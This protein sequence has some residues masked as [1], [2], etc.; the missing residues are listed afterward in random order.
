M[1]DEEDRRDWTRDVLSAVMLDQQQ[2]LCV[3]HEVRSLSDTLSRSS[4][5]PGH[6]AGNHT[7]KSSERSRGSTRFDRNA[8]RTNSAK[9]EVDAEDAAMSAEGQG[10]GE[11]KGEE[12]GVDDMRRGG[13]GFRTWRHT[14]IQLRT[15]FPGGGNYSGVGVPLDPHESGQ[16]EGGGMYARLL[17]MR[18]T[19]VEVM[20]MKMHVQHKGTD[21]VSSEGGSVRGAYL[22]PNLYSNNLRAE[23]ADAKSN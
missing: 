14:L 17:E 9:A 22:A 10:E 8:A 4:A 23:L 18:E 11:G 12:R 6:S 19:Q 16:G 3:L 15:M 1:F 20:K 21:T 5:L 7:D 13:L 2:E